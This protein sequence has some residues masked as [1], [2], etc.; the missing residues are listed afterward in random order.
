VPQRDHKPLSPK[1]TSENSNLDLFDQ[2]SEASYEDSG[3]APA[4]QP[5]VSDARG[6]NEGFRVGQ[7]RS[8]KAQELLE[9]LGDLPLRDWQEFHK[10]YLSIL[11]PGLA[12]SFEDTR[13]GL[14]SRDTGVRLEKPV[15]TFVPMEHSS[16][17]S[18]SSLSRPSDGK[19]HPT[20]GVPSESSTR[21]TSNEGSGSTKR[22]AIR[23][24]RKRLKDSNETSLPSI[25]RSYEELCSKYGR[26]P[27]EGF[28]EYSTYVRRVRSGDAQRSV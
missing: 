15:P 25:L 3:R 22:T 16:R 6:P 9:L 24:A 21:G 1:M 23:K 17:G 28:A 2:R 7:Q 8:S 10:G 26:G 4:D 11:P 18:T 13:S 20:G 5:Q 12:G 19:I 27:E 14:Q